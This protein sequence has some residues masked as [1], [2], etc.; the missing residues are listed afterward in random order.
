M[1]WKKN[2]FFL[3]IGIRTLYYDD[4]DI[5]YGSMVGNLQA[6][7]I[8]IAVYSR[9]GCKCFIKRNFT[10][11]ERIIYYSENYPTTKTSLN[12][13]HYDLMSTYYDDA[14][15]CVYIYISIILLFL[16]YSRR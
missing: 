12:N 16:I 3:T 8:T 6:C 15:L 5:I 14:L 9:P 10:T 13:F 11:A 1:Y 4:A 7:V 2:L